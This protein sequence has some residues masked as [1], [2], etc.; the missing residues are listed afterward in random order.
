MKPQL[1]I[2]VQ[3]EYELPIFKIKHQILLSLSTVLTE[4]ILHLPRASKTDLLHDI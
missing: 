3:S 1:S 2:L 4:G